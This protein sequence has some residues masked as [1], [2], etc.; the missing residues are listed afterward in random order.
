V[1]NCDTK[2]TVQE[3]ILDQACLPW[4][5]VVKVEHYWLTVDA[6]TGPMTLREDSVSYE[7]K[8]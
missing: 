4:H 5:E 7:V 2:P 8:K 1:T 3:P 6:L